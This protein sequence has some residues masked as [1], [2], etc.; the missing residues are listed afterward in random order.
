MSKQTQLSK[1]CIVCGIQKP[2]AAFLQMTGAQGTIY[3]NVCTACRGVNAKSNETV[4]LKEDDHGSTSSGLRIDSTAR[5]L[6]EIKEKKFETEKDELKREDRE[7]RDKLQHDRTELIDKRQEAEKDHRYN[8]IEIRQKQ[9]FLSWQEKKTAE[10]Q[11]TKQLQQKKTT[12]ERLHDTLEHQKVVA[13]KEDMRLNTLDLSAPILGTGYE[14]RFRSSIFLS[15][16]AWLGF[17]SNAPIVQLFKNLNVP[18]QQNNPVKETEKP[19]LKLELEKDSPIEF[20]NKSWRN[21]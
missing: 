17:E 6:A 14:M 2:L 7:K 5:N 3:G 11:I 20:T 4:A 8:Y 16:L 13:A 10:K 12:I 21:R 15:Y 1:T 19:G 9:G 18:Q